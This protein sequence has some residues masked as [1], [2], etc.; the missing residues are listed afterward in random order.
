MADSRQ[1]CSLTTIGLGGTPLRYFRPADTEELRGTLQQCRREE[2]PWR[3]LGGGSNVLAEDGPLPCAVLHIASPHFCSIQRTG[4]ESVRAGAGVPTPAL[5][6]FCRAEGLGGLEFLTGVPGT[7]GGAVAGNAGAWG[8]QVSDTLT[9]VHVVHPDGAERVLPAEQLAFS[10]RRAELGGAVV[11]A[12]EF[13]LQPRDSQLVGR[14][15]AALAQKRREGQPPGPGSAGCIFKNPPG[16]SA[17]RLVDRC[18]L[19]GARIGGAE[20]SCKHANFI[21]NRGDASASDVLGLIGMMKEAVHER[22]G[23][24]LNLEIR[25][26]SAGREAP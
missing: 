16:A 11:V 17:G 21:L 20:I 1:L 2:L 5:L 23:V 18:G 9:A 25:H 22:F 13:A 19:K 26:W 14:R 3:V 6:G 15:M 10:Y 8:R 4:A 7:V 24:E 12:A